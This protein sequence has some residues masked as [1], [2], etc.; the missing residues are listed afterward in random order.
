MKKLLFMIFTLILTLS[1][2]AC[3]TKDGNLV[4]LKDN[5]TFEEEE[6]SYEIEQILFS[7]SFQS[8]DSSVEIITNNNKLKV[9]ASLGLTECSSVNVNSITKKGSE[10]NIHVSA[11]YSK[12]SLRLAVPQVFMEIDKSKLKGIDNL[13]FNIV[14][15]DYNP[16]KIK[17]G[18]NEVLN[19]LEANYKLSTKTSPVFTLSRSGES[20]VWSITYNSIFDRETPEVPLVNLFAQVDAISGDIIE[21]EKVNI[22]SALD[23]GHVLNYISDDLILY[24]KSI[25][26]NVTNK[27]KEQ[28]WLYNTV[29][30]EKTMIFYS[31]YNIHS[32]EPNKNREL[33][34]IVEVND[35]GSELYIVSLEDNRTYKI[36]LEEEFNPSIMSWKDENIL[37]LVDSNKYG[38]V[39]YSFDIESN[40]STLVT[41]FQRMIEYLVSNGK[42]FLVV[43]DSEED[44]TKRISITTDWRDFN[45]IGNGFLPKYIDENHIAYLKK[46]NTQDSSTLIIYNIGEGRTIRRIEENIVNYRVISPTNLVYIVKNSINNYALINYSLENKSSTNIA[47]LIDQK[48]YYNENDSLVYLNTILPFE[49]DKREMIYIIDLNK[50]N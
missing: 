46:D 45:I 16:L 5:I 14:Y 25:V 19:K 32:V 7:K 27:T 48:I 30:N 37:Y 44:N 15:D 47:N 17:F 26:D 40:K 28:L 24:K 11:R 36:N 1:L 2:V 31:N 29:N 22:S 13:K 3:N 10:I 9:L 39:I 12:N 38:T 50:L 21:S 23:E 8:I 41:K 35:N 43:E 42:S 20:L 4:E 33:I 18:I 34:S 6:I 49:S